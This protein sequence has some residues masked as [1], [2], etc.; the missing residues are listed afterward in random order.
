MKNLYLT[1]EMSCL[2]RAVY[3]TLGGGLC[4]IAIVPPT[5]VYPKVV[6]VVSAGLQE[7][8]G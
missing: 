3:T 7:S 2:K 4:P 5:A 6:E 1:K 8:P